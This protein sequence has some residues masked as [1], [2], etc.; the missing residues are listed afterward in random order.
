MCLFF[1]PLFKVLGNSGWPRC[2][3]PCSSWLHIL[4]AW[5][6]L[7]R[8][9]AKVSTVFLILFVFV[10]R[11][12]TGFF[13]VW[14][15]KSNRSVAVAPLKL[16]CLSLQYVPCIYCSPFFGGG[17][18]VHGSTLPTCPLFLWRQK[19]RQGGSHVVLPWISW[20][21]WQRTK[22]LKQKTLHR[23]TAGLPWYGPLW[24]LSS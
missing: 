16:P 2:L 7:W 14:E 12:H 10:N 4:F 8:V 11:R 5:L 24:F 9:F 23:H 19:H 18:S 20:M 21:G 6:F 15:K 22:C 17:Q 1:P 13:S 3:S